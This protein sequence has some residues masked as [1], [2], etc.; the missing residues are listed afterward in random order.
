MKRTRTGR[1]KQRLKRY[2]RHMS[3]RMSKHMSKRQSKQQPNSLGF[4]RKGEIV[5]FSRTDYYQETARSGL[6]LLWYDPQVL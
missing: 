4:V 2:S 5:L 3:K 1:T 6:A